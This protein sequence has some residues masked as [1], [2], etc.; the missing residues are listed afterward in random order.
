MTEEQQIVFNSIFGKY[1][2]MLLTKTQMSDICNVSTKTLDRDRDR[3][4]GCE[5]KHSG[6]R[7]Y[8]PLHKVVK[9]LDT[10]NKTNY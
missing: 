1:G 4:K 3:G 10:Y 8:Y 2:N 6:G 5:W 9:F 7:I